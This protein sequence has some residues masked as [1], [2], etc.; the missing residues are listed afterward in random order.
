M[1]W[2]AESRLRVN[3][4]FA[5]S[6]YVSCVCVCALLYWSLLDAENGQQSKKKKNKN[7]RQPCKEV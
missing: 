5:L 7:R 3:S 2:Q 6:G 4:V 1:Y